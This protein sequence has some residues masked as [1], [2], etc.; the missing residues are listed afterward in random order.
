MLSACA[1]TG[2]RGCDMKRYLYCTALLAMSQ[3]VICRYLATNQHDIVLIYC[4]VFESEICIK[5]YF[6]MHA[7]L[8]IVP[9]K[10][11]RIPFILFSL[12]D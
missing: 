3:S 2:V 8:W 7:K 10:G 4:Q 9:A 1:R 6:H 5:K 11:A 12:V